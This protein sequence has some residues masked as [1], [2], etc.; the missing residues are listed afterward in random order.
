M[1][2]I[3]V[4][5]E[6]VGLVVMRRALAF[7]VVIY[8]QITSQ[9]HQPV[10]EVTLFRVVLFQRSVN[11]NKNFLGQV[12]G[13]ISTRS[14]PIGQVVNPSRV[15]MN[16]LFPGRTIPGATPADQ[17]GSFVG[18]Q[19][20]CSPHLLFPAYVVIALAGSRRKDF[21]MLERNYDSLKR[22]VPA[23]PKLKDC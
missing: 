23:K 17:F 22:K 1:E 4:I 2:V 12:L 9:P 7:S 19:R 15:A 5:G 20:S 10:L 8:D 21:P 18:S 6:I 16:N 14:K 13:R 3:S 11:P